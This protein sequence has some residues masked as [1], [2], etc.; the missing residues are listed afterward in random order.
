[1]MF[2]IGFG[3]FFVLPFF[4][5][6]QPMTPLKQ[7]FIPVVTAAQGGGGSFWRSDVWL[8]NASNKA[9]SV[10]LWVYTGTRGESMGKV[11]SLPAYG[12]LN[13]NNVVGDIGLSENSIYL[14]NINSNEN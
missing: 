12:S 4:L 7:G 9:T 6:G 10:E 1:M 8:T 14:L 2:R 5:F 11:Y 13:I 3:L